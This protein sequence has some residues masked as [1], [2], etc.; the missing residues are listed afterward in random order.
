MVSMGIKKKVNKEQIINIVLNVFIVIF[1]LILIFSV[2]NK[3][4]VSFFGKDY[5]D[6]FGYS[7][8]EVQ[9]G[10]M[11]PE[12]SPGDWIIVKST[13]N[14][15]LNDVVTYKH[16]GE[17]ITHRVIG[18]SGGTYITKGDANNSKDDP[19][20]EK[21][22]I[23]VVV[24]TLPTFG[25]LKKT[26]FNPVV[27]VSIIITILI[28]NY[29]MNK[30]KKEESET[31]EMKRDVL[32]IE[33]KVKTIGANTI[34]T[35]KERA[36]KIKEQ[37]L[38]KTETKS[39]VEEPEE[40]VEGEYRELAVLEDIELQSKTEEEL[41][42]MFE[43]DASFIPVDVSELDET[44]LEIAQNEIEEE[45]IDEFKKIQEEKEDEED[46]KEAPNKINLEL[47]E[48]GKKSK[49]IIEKFISVKIE[50]LNEVINIL[51]TDEKTYVNEPTIKNKLM[52]YY[53][54]SK[55]YN[56]YGETE[57]SS[58]KKQIDK[59]EK[60]IT[61]EANLLKKK[62]SGSD[63]KYGEKVD[64]FLKIFTVLANIENAKDAIIDKKAKEEF[65]KNQIMQITSDLDWD[66]TKYKNVISEII[67]IQRNYIGIVEY[68]CKKFETNLFDLELLSLK[69]NKNIFVTSL[70]HNI[71]F[72]KMYSDYIIDK[73]YNE[74][75]IAENKISILLNLL[76][77]KIIKDMINS[78]FNKKYVVYIP[79]SLYTKEKK[80]E[81]VLGLIED[82]RAKDSVLILISMSRLS[83]GK[84]LIKKLK[85]K[86][87]MFAIPITKEENLNSKNYPTMNL[88][89]YIF[90]D[91][92]I[93]NVVKTL[94]AFPEDIFD[95]MIYENIIEKIGDF[96]GE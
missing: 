63:A 34:K 21:Q 75:V 28:F 35:L 18:K 96:G 94:T 55:Y 93:S 84:T 2:Y 3:V 49:N 30:N 7:V 90:V 31:K 85:K 37:K 39:K 33:K 43:E 13:K 57:V 64:K 41:N 20:D 1:G 53:I 78:D 44:F 91:K 51:D 5:S 17:F 19:I 76:S 22:I 81:K 15:K 45:P 87:Y 42:E 47:L 67:K 9:T 74:G 95:K 83:S 72:S 4:Q 36:K 12:I 92:N 25:F 8:F 65:Y 50:E 29:V 82:E 40:Q 23:G 89:D 69:S 27:L 24:K 59:I 88:A 52:G 56:Y 14:V 86:G 16:S 71:T 26:I 6:F 77:I 73:T 70:E 48:T 54:D 80:L 10:S 32:E 68:L 62:Y 66:Q 60:Y 61:K 58:S 46:E 38:Q 11:E 79:E